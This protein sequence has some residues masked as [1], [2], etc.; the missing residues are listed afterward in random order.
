MSKSWEQI[1]GGYA[2]DTLSEEE[3]HQLFDAA[4][5]DQAIFDALADEESLKALLADSEARQRILTSLRATEN[6]QEASTSQSSR[7]S[8]F[9]QPSYLAW[10]G[11]LA[12]MGLAFMFG[13]QMEKNWGPMVGEN[14]KQERPEAQP[15][16]KVS[17]ERD[18]VVAK[19]PQPSKV[20]KQ[21][22]VVALKKEDDEDRRSDTKLQSART[23]VP[24]VEPKADEVNPASR[25][26]SYEPV[27]K[28]ETKEKRVKSEVKS[29]S[30]PVRLLE[31]VSQA[32]DM[33]TESNQPPGD[34]PI[35]AVA[36]TD[37]AEVAVP[38]SPLLTP[39]K[40]SLADQAVREESSSQPGA[41]DLFYAAPRESRNDSR[42]ASADAD[43]PNAK[44][45][46]SKTTQAQSR[47]KEQIVRRAMGIRYSF[48]EEMNG[49]EKEFGDG[50][51]FKGSWGNVRL[52]I[53]A[54]QAGF[55]YVLA[56]LGRGQWQRLAHTTRVAG[57][58]T[59]DEFSVEPH[60]IKEFHLGVV[61]NR[62]EKLVVS[63]IRV[64][65]SPRPL[66]N[67]GPLLGR[68]INMSGLQIERTKETVYVVQS[69]GVSVR[70][71]RVDIPLQK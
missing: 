1:L 62:M 25:V 2:T 5:H 60:Q 22:P 40:E 37:F 27:R 67:L 32:P 42:A 9:C 26:E 68:T 46:S 69:G 63:S 58:V 50:L 16:K 71:L 56:P 6:F 43:V 23:S 24:L 35:P 64:L 49:Q 20:E 19:N 41:L 36:G 29:N 12:A 14:Q 13:W 28:E 34:P 7:M 18:I 57:E 44:K 8:W 48:V 4:L 38:P 31:Q 65:F 10:A 39:S 33:S 66:K 17:P 30:P 15:E 70:P 45:K 21:K 51:Q 59:Q 3:K 11:S 52:T 53:E 61:T 54:N 47:D 55:L